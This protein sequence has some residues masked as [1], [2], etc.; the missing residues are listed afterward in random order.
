MRREREEDWANHVFG[1]LTAAGFVDRAAPLRLA[2]L[3]RFVRSSCAVAAI[4]IA[5]S[6]AV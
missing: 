1:G 5:S 3:L 4:V 2:P 6:L